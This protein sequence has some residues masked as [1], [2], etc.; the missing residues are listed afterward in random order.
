MKETLSTWRKSSY[1]NPDGDCVEVAL[2]VT[3]AAV[4]DSKDPA[5]EALR[6]GSAAWGAF[7]ALVNTSDSE[8]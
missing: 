3:T 8:S 5:K 6:V 2:G 7:L 4:R 1:S